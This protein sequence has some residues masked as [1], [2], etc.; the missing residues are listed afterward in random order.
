MRTLCANQVS[1]VAV[2]G[3]G[4]RGLS[5]K[6]VCNASPLPVSGRGTLIACP[7]RSGPTPGSRKKT[8]SRTLTGKRCSTRYTP[9]SRSP[10]PTI[11]FPAG[12]TNPRWLRSSRTWSRRRSPPRFVGCFLCLAHGYTSRIPGISS[13]QAALPKLL[14]IGFDDKTTKAVADIEETVRTRGATSPYDESL[15]KEYWMMRGGRDPYPAQDL[16]ATHYCFHVHQLLDLSIEESIDACLSRVEHGLDIAGLST[17]F[18]NGSYLDS[19]AI[20]RVNKV[21]GWDYDRVSLPPCVRLPLLMHLLEFRL[22]T[23]GELL[24]AVNNAAGLVPPFARPATVE[25]PAELV[26]E[27]SPMP[28]PTLQRAQARAPQVASKTSQRLRFSAE[29]LSSMVSGGESSS[30]HQQRLKDDDSK[31]G[32]PSDTY[33]K[34]AMEPHEIDQA[35]ELTFPDGAAGLEHTYGPTIPDRDI[36]MLV[37]QAMFIKCIVNPADDPSKPKQLFKCFLG[38]NEENLKVCREFFPDH[39]LRSVDHHHPA[40]L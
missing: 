19:L 6:T 5:N 38:P 25:A 3:E 26:L 22:S 8:T 36:A 1:A 27:G 16:A 4:C 24:R 32:P 12:G 28:T 40:R 31:S 20:P 21:M 9:R 29:T 39:A 7:A 11:W 13:L 33:C 35:M 17:N 15:F 34:K 30:Q 14:A 2:S 10:L 23:L 37:K 18:I